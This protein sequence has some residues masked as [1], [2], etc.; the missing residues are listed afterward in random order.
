MSWA[1]LELAPGARATLGPAPGVVNHVRGNYAVWS[2]DRLHRYRLLRDLR[3][4]DL[5][6][7]PPSPRRL[8]AIMANPSKASATDN[9]PT[10]RRVIGLATSWGFNVV[11]VVN[12]DAF[13]ATDPDDL[14]AADA[15]GVDVCGAYNHLCISS[16][17][18]TAIA[19]GGDVFCAWGNVAR[20]RAVADVEALLRELGVPIRGWR[21]TSKGRPE[22][23]LYAP[24]S[25][26][27][28]EGPNGG[29]AI[30]R[31]ATS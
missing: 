12:V 15:R 3:K 26:R 25:A 16:A 30:D 13:V 4:H 31:R 8:C 18:S 20:A 28:V 5:L 1:D 11:E 29:R 9:D 17:V 24:G 7:A 6:F 27:M 2:R 22:H 10:V 19:G 21:W 23:P 14:R